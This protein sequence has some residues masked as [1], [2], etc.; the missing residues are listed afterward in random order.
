MSIAYIQA[1]Q[2]PSRWSLQSGTRCTNMHYKLHNTK[3]K[4]TVYRDGGARGSVQGRPPGGGDILRGERN[5]AE[6]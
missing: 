5:N 3:K 4:L 2:P 6:S 1:E